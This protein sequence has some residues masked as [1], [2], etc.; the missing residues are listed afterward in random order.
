MKRS[1]C[2]DTPAS[3]RNRPG[4]RSRVAMLGMAGTVLALLATWALGRSAR[5]Q[6]APLPEN[7]PGLIAAP[8]QTAIAARDE[9]RLNL[10]S[11]RHDISPEELGDLM[12]LHKKFRE[13]IESYVQGPPDDPTL[14]NKMGI[15]YHQL[16]MLREARESYLTAL[17][18]RPA[19]LE[20]A[21]NLGTIEYSKKNY[22]RAISWYRKA[23]HMEARETALAA[24]VYMNLGV[25][26]FGRKNYEKANL[27]F[28][29]A[30]RLDPNVFEDRGSVGQILAERNVEE[31]SRFH[32][33]MAKLYARQG[34]KE[35]AI[36][37]LRR[38]LEEGYTDRKTPWPDDSDFAGL[39]QLPEFQQLV[40]VPPR[41]L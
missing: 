40:A 32:F 17:Q 33:Y 34:R 3:A 12:M 25:A 31:R 41:T 26:W 11:T 8:I 1:N 16:G 28:Q 19:Y 20:A 4:A 21:N 38:S 24:S 2:S 6:D 18:L 30:L 10:S 36:Q 27:S 9:T 22:R 15:A 29:A 14:K 35:L 13:A 23:L 37:Y 5:A 7:H 39:R